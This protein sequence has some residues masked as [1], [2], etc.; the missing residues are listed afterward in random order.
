MQQKIFASLLA[1]G[2]RAE[3]P[4]VQ[5][6]TLWMRQVSG[7]KTIPNLEQ[8]PGSWETGLLQDHPSVT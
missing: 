1:E 2:T 8:A 5:S 3:A 6:T 4:A 7:W